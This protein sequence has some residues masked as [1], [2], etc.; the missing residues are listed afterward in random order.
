MTASAPASPLRVGWMH[1]N[2]VRDW[3]G[4]G[5]DRARRAAE[6]RFGARIRTEVLDELGDGDG[7]SAAA[8]SLAS[9][10]S[11]VFV[12]DVTVTDR[13]ERVA[14][15]HPTTR[16]VHC[17]GRRPSA[18]VATYRAA[19]DEHAFVS[20]MLAGAATRTGRLGLVEGARS[21]HDLLYTNAWIL[22]ALRS[23]PD[24]RIELRWLGTYHAPDQAERERAAVAELIA[25]GVD[26]IGGNLAENPAVVAAAGEGGALVTAHDDRL[27]HLPQV[28]DASY[29]EWSPYVIRSIAAV[30]DGTWSARDDY[31]RASD[32]VVLNTPPAPWLP[33]RARTRANDVASAIRAGRF[34]IWAGPIRDQAGELVVPAGSRLTEEYLD[35]DRLDW[36]AGSVTD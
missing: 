18:N 10:A 7:W 2:S 36:I 14:A 28:L 11:L 35:S 17:Q 13:L 15:S 34:D 21:A 22:G 32:G 30:L 8:D 5:H 20:G 16:F 31:L 27:S 4:H 1:A 24:A 25:A 23:A 26:V 3:W 12:C 6:R 9:R 33:E 19:R 29:L